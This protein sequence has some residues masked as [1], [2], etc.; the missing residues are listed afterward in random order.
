MRAVTKHTGKFVTLT[1]GI[2]PGTYELKA[3]YNQVATPEP[4]EVFKCPC[5]A[6]PMRAVFDV[7]QLGFW[8]DDYQTFF[9][10]APCKSVVLFTYSF[11]HIEPASR[12]PGKKKAAQSAV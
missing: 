2:A 6:E 3:T 8:Q 11:S 5:C 12:K 4:G 10:C 1:G 7:Q 9:A